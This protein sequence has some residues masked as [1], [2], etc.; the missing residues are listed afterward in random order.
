VGYL[1]L[2]GI[3]GF[4]GD[5]QLNYRPEQTFETFYNFAVNKHFWITLDYQRIVNPAYNGDRGPVSLA[6]VR[7]HL[8][9]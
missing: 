8:E 7:L 2:G 4:I 1:K 6:G 5:G 3:D 9:L